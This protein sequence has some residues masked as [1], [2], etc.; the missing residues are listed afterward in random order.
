MAEV[1]VASP[2]PQVALVNF[3]LGLAPEKLD[4]VD[5]IFASC[6]TTLAASAE[7]GRVDGPAKHAVVSLLKTPVLSTGKPLAILA[8]PHYAQLMAF[9]PL[10]S[11]KEVAVLLARILRSGGAPIGS[12]GETDAV[13]GFLQP[14]VMDAAE[15]AAAQAELDDD[16]EEFDQ[17][18]SM[19]AALIHQARSA[20]ADLPAPPRR[21]A[22][23]PPR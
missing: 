21:R 1:T 20:R 17:E 14:L 16:V 8:L 9:L 13:L 22:A 11:R 15:D 6:G 23:A 19:V 10:D 12:V 2:A 7:G 4:Y 3:A 5:S 18:Q